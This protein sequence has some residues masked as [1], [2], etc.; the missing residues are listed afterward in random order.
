M[1]IYFNLPILLFLLTNNVFSQIIYTEINPSQLLCSSGCEDKSYEID[2]NNDNIVDL[3]LWFDSFKLGAGCESTQRI[4]LF[5][6]KPIDTAL[7]FVDTNGELAFFNNMDTIKEA[8]NFF[9]DEYYCEDD[10]IYKCPFLLSSTYWNCESTPTEYTGHYEAFY[11][12]YIGLKLKILDNYHY[13]WIKVF[14]KKGINLEIKSLAYNTTP[15]ETI[16]IN[17]P[18]FTTIETTAIEKIQCFPNPVEDF[19]TIDINN[20]SCIIEITDL[21]GRI[22]HKKIYNT[23]CFKVPTFSWIKGIYIVCVTTENSRVTKKIIKK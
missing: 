18:N 8:N 3:L 14:K 10:D 7:I 23:S 11:N 2:F 16:V 19:L 21:S 17:D 12:K 13:C 6:I 22:I 9:F 20:N 1:K 4:E 15:N 5:S